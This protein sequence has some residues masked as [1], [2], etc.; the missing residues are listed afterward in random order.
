M[1]PTVPDPAKK[2]SMTV[3]RQMSAG[4]AV[5]VAAMLILLVVSTIALGNVA[6]A[7]D[8]VIER[9]SK[10]VADAHRLEAV[11]SDRSA[12]IRAF[13]LTGDQRELSRVDD[14]QEEYGT[15]L[16]ELE[17]NVHSETGARMLDRI[18]TA[19]AA[20]AGQL[21]EV[22][23]TASR[24]ASL[25]EV[26]QLAER[27]VFPRRE[28]LRTAVKQFV[29]RQEMLISQGVERSDAIASRALQLLWTLAGVAVALG[30][31]TAVLVTRRVSG[32]LR[33]LALTVD[34]AASDVLAGTTQQVTGF[35]EQA[36]AVQQT[37]ATVDELVQTAQQSAERARTVADRSQRSVDVSAEGIK[38][39]QGTTAGM[40]AVRQQ[41]HTIAQGVV[42][43]AEQAQAISDIINA[44]EDIA[45]QTHLLALNAAVEAA[46]A[47][48]HGKGFG[49]VAAEVKTLADQSRRSTGQI[50]KI[51]GEVQR[52]TN[53]AVML[54][55]A[56]TKSVDDGMALVVQTGD[57][58]NE[59]ADTVADATLAAEQITASSTQQAIATSQISH[60][61]KD[62]DKV[63]EQNLAAAR[64]AEQ[65]ARDLAEVASAMKKLVGAAG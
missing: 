42:A 7:K 38:A 29:E 48:E 43:L 30:V 27:Q 5:L 21:D 58:I 35:T 12:A 62:V 22:V 50:A 28:A 23:A 37:V 9:D 44:V 31:T 55:E 41:V 11:I 14:L 32:T 17:A 26:S 18:V 60:A 53:T 33:S 61:M 52:G 19:E 51:L 25:E 54:T 4:F 56:G 10:L 6:S 34:G 13:M 24:G 36:A 45:D 39:V 46:R 59:L 40:E 64:Q 16:A 8:T 65:A 1:P 63:M 15:V 57:T 47:G 49:V 2:S 20:W 3:G